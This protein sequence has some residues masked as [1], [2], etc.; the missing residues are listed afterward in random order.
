MCQPRLQQG[1]TLLVPV[2]F[3]SLQALLA[4]VT[5]CN[6]SSLP[7]LELFIFI[8]IQFSYLLFWARDEKREI[9]KYL[10]PVENNA[11]SFLDYHYSA[12]VATNVCVCVCECVSMKRRGP[13]PGSQNPTEELVWDCDIPTA[14]LRQDT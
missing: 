11:S 8:L 12:W 1:P 3:Q 5:V 2:Y 6:I 10:C 9:I 7:F 13:H 4:L 14:P